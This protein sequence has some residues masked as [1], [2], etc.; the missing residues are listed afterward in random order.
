MQAT[1]ANCPKGPALLAKAGV[2][3]SDALWFYRQHRTGIVVPDSARL[4]PI[5]RKVNRFLARNPLP[6]HARLTLA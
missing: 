3:L 2:T 4:A 1:T 6:A 5:R